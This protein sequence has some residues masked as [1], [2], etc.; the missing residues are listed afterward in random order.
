MQ[1]KECDTFEISIY[2]AGF[3][4]RINQLS[5]KF[6]TK[7]LLCVSVNNEVYC[8]N[9]GSELGA[10]IKLIN[11]PKFPRSLDELMTLATELAEFLLQETDQKSCT[12][13][14]PEKTIWVTIDDY[15]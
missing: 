10:R 5:Q 7:N 1:H 9:H 8:Y 2:I 12:V 15:K 14:G 6:A 13:V 11:Y 4:C 3:E